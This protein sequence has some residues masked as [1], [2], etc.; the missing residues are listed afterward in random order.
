MARSHRLHARRHLG[1]DRAQLE[2]L[3]VDH[4]RDTQANGE[5]VPFAAQHRPTTGARE[6]ARQR[7]QSHSSSRPQS[8]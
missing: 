2:Q 5:G 6:R 4:V 3:V 1:H 8:F 7:L